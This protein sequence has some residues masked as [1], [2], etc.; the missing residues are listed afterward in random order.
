MDE[1]LKQK[2]NQEI[3]LI[4]CTYVCALYNPEFV[5]NNFHRIELEFMIEIELI[6]EVLQAQLR[7][8]LIAHA[9]KKKKQQN[10]QELKL[11]T[12]ID[13]LEE[14]LDKYIENDSWVKELNDKKKELEE[15]R[16]YKLKGALIRSR[17]QNIN[18]G[19]KP[20]KTF[21]NLENN[22]FIF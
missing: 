19:E 12:E 17:W 16:E 10:K 20:S 2:I 9:S 6:W 3:E 5:K 8:I 21:L 18:M 15:I 22:N 11:N 14:N 4:I 7:Y 1:N 13:H